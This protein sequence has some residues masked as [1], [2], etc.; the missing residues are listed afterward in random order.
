MYVMAQSAVV[1]SAS[2]SGSVWWFQ[3]RT[4]TISFLPL[5]GIVWFG[6]HHIW[7]RPTT[8]SYLRPLPCRTRP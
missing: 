8:I 4:A 1:Y 6:I 2:P 7:G 3:D 5:P